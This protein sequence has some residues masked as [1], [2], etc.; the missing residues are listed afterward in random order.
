MSDRALRE[1]ERRASTGDEDARTALLWEQRRAGTLNNAR[2]CLL[3]YLGDVP[4]ILVC[5]D[6]FA[7]DRS[8]HQ[9][10]MDCGGKEFDVA[11]I[12]E[13]T[14]RE[15][16][17]T[18]GR[19][20]DSYGPDEVWG[21]T[22]EQESEEITQWVNGLNSRSK[23][24]AAIAMDVECPVIR[25][26]HPH[27]AS[28]QQCDDDCFVCGG[29]DKYR[30]IAPFNQWLAAQVAL[31]VG[32]AAMDQFGPSSDE[33]MSPQTQYES[34][35]L[36]EATDRWVACPCDVHAQRTQSGLPMWVTAPMQIARAW[37]GMDQA[38]ELQFPGALNGVTEI[39]GH[40]RVLAVAQ[41]AAL[42]VVM[43]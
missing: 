6:A 1:L 19:G 43:P 25:S 2:A 29:T 5:E 36:F 10:C 42:K 34:L 33:P 26:G 22:E 9:S 3:G 31:A 32:R 38:L 7:F 37:L 20:L 24:M 23:G 13:E 4:S 39:L 17:G 40:K 8:Q 41:S 14:D 28:W 16:C 15:Y 18:C 21:Q 12:G 11:C 35:V 30:A 27:R